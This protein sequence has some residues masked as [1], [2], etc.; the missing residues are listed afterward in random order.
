MS[1][2]M[3]L[4]LVLSCMLLNHFSVAEVL[5]HR[6]TSVLSII[7]WLMFSSN[8]LLIMPMLDLVGLI[9]LHVGLLEK[10]EDRLW[11]L[12]GRLGDKL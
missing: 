4:Q 10:L 1:N 2:M 7:F 12:W 9:S 11:E 3:N 5:L 8:L 6:F